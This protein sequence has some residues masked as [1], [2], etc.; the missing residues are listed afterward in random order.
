MKKIFF[1]LFL[2]YTTL[3]FAQNVEFTKENFM[4]DKDALSIARKDIETGDVFYIRGPKYYKQAINPYVAAN[5]FNPNNALLNFKLGK[6]Y[7]YSSFKLKSI[8]HLEKA[9]VLNPKIDPKIHYYLGIAYHLNMKWDKAIDEFKTFRKKLSP[10]DSIKYKDEIKKHIDECFVGKDQVQNPNR[11]VSGNIE[12]VGPQ[13]NSQ[14]SEYKPV[15][16][17]DES[18]MMFTSCRPNTTGGKIANDIN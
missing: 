1:I 5:Q 18:I 10:E 2:F 12:N 7:L 8:P 17:A 11:V 6:C 3:A 16:S 9:L 14:Y 13:V 4:E 15:V